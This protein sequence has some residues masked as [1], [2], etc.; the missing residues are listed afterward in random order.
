MEYQEHSQTP[1]YLPLSAQEVA[2][3]EGFRQLDE[4]AQQDV[5]RVVRAL[6]GLPA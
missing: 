4:Q 2:L 3:L 6:Q 1:Q 5:L